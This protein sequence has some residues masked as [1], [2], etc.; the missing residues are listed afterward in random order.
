[1]NLYFLVEGRRTEPQIYRRW[2]NHAFP[3]L[4][5]V[6]SAKRMT[7]SC[8]RIRSAGGYPQILQRLEGA[9]QEINSSGISLDALFVCVDAEEESYH[10]RYE[11]VTTFLQK[12]DPS[13]HFVVIVQDCCIETWQLG[14]RS[15]LRPP[16]RTQALRELKSF[17][18]VS[19]DDPEK[20]PTRAGYET[21]A[22]FHIDYLKSVLRDRGLRYTKKSI[23]TVG[24]SRHLGA[25]VLRHE[26]TSHLRS[27]GRLVTAWRELGAEL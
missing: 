10:E 22:G 27:F 11:K 9:V 14:N 4:Q 25:L 1:M 20:M 23:G 3:E 24:D 5:E 7:S 18:D 2:L 13:F 6:T 15:L 16:P 19:R 26:D 8:F 21:R 17:Y 12:L